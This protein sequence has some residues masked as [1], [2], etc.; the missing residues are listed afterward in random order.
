MIDYYKRRASHYDAVYGRPG[1]RPDLRRLAA[2][3]PAAQAGRRVLEPAAGTGR[4]TAPI[5]ASAHATDA[6]AGPLAT[7]ETREHFPTSSALRAAAGPCAEDVSV[8]ELR[9]S[10]LPTFRT[11]R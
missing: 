6:N 2:L 9:Y 4:W 1:R 11:R 10:W 5:A 8:T 3:I 7:A